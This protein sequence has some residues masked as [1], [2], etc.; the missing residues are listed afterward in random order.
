[1][2]ISLF[3]SCSPPVATLTVEGGEHFREKTPVSFTY[4][5]ST[6]YQS[7][8][9]EDLSNG[10]QTVAQRKDGDEW[11]FLLDSPLQPNETRE[12]Q[13]IEKPAKLAGVN[14]EMDQDKIT[15]R[16]P[17]K[18]IMTYYTS[19]QSPPEGSPQ[20]YQKSGFIHPFY[21]PEGQVLTDGF[22][23]HHMHQHGIFFA[24]TNT[25]YK[26]EKVDFWNQHSGL[27]TVIHSKLIKAEPGP[28]FG[29]MIA[30][31]D[32]LAFPKGDTTVVLKETWDI[33]VYNR[34]D[35]FVWDITSKQVCQTD[36]P[37]H[38][39]KYH[40]GG[41]GFRGNASWD[42]PEPEEGLEAYGPGQGRFLSSEGKTRTNGNHTRPKWASLY[43]EVD[44]VTAGLAAMD[45]PDNFRFPQPVRIHPNMPYFV[46]SPMVDGQFDL[47]KG[48]E[49]VSR[50]RIV[51][52][53]GE[54]DS[55][56]LDQIWQDYADAPDASVR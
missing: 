20:Y 53:Q 3:F 29:R 54:P 51:S 17:D 25:K 7:M 5:L 14:T 11:I 47:N 44:G 27:G 42:A 12:Y 35:Y 49:Y 4:P 52:F 50:Y 55:E 2:I 34:E 10:N 26:G 46:F 30:E 31:L 9:L 13:I 19:I 41:M 21:S 22:P 38:V 32:H 36:S 56:K 43:G 48:E 23:S 24:W 37:L 1:M 45:H 8:I 33:L 18:D 15:F 39:V 16:T 40:Y 6:S 28:V